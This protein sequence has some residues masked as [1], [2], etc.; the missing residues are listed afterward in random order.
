MLTRAASR[1]IRPVSIVLL[2]G[3]IAAP[4]AGRGDPATDTARAAAANALVDVRPSALAGTWYPA[5]AETLAASIDGLLD[6]AVSEPPAGTLRALVAP[7]AGYAYSGA[8]AA[9][10]FKLVRGAR[11]DR[12]V[13]LAPSHRADFPGLSIA[14]VDAYRTPLGTVPLD[15]EV[16]DRLR[17]SPLVQ[18]HPDAH[19]A[20]HAV[21]IELPLLQRALAPGWRLVP[22]LVGRLG[23]D[24]YA[25]AAELLRPYL[26]GQTLLVVSSDFT[27]YGPRFGYVPFP[28]DGQVQAHIRALDDGAV[29]RITARDGP[30]LL[31]YR[32]RTG[33]TVCGVR[34]LALLL[35]LLPADGR[36]HRLAYA[37]SGEL[38]G[39]WSNSVSYV[40]LAVTA[41]APVADPRGG[42]AAVPSPVPEVAPQ[43]AP[44]AAPPAA[45]PPS[46]DTAELRRLHALAVLGIRRA[47]LGN[48]QV[49]DEEILAAVA[50]LPPALERRS[51]AF[52]TLWRNGALRGCVGRAGDELPLYAA[53]MQSGFDAA[54]KD[55]RFT[56]LRTDELDGLDVDVNVLS[57]PRPIDGIDELHLGEHGVTL[58]RDG[59]FALYLP[60]VAPSMGWDKETNLS[61]LAVKAGLP[62][63][64][65]RDGAELEVFTST[66]YRA[67][68]APPA[69]SERAEKTT[70][71]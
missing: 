9:A 21:E 23:G 41:P 36:V 71:R 3:A 20:E 58:S 7:H 67:P 48:A 38:T 18:A 14:G 6:D 66:E 50:D 62:R 49:P 11:Y 64:A 2:A 13:V 52:V 26:D 1:L 29:A 22:I 35:D 43:A 12:V 63:D 19:A 37:T 5:D 8:A 57:P 70:E 25:A 54:R 51:G 55:H 65:W 17:A 39:D 47:V 28:A 40:A 68:Y 31:R 34:P 53:V 10:A 32:E 60:E 56:P 16:V 4:A 15:A 44:P 46:L 24:D 61:E 59:H 42:A 45:A 69:V 30:G 27:H 33:I